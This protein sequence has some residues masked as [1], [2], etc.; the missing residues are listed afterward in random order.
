MLRN[1]VKIAWRSLSGNKLYT[2]INILG[3]ALGVC[4]CLVIYLVTSFELS[5][6]RF[7]PDRERIYRVV[8]ELRDNEGGDHKMGGVTDPMAMTMRSELSG[9][10]TVAG[11]Y[12]YYTKVRIPDGKK[13]S[14]QFDQPKY[15]TSSDIIITEPQY[16]DIFHYN[17]LAG[18]SQTAL[19]EPFRV[20]LSGRQVQR[21]F[22]NL[23]PDQA[24]G[25][26]VIYGDSLALTVSG[27]VEDWAGNSDLNFKDFISFATVANSPLK[28]DIDM[29]AWGMWNETTQAF[30]K[31][32][33]NVSP[34]QVERQFPAFVNRHLVMQPGDKN[35]LALQPLSDLHFN[36]DY[37]DSFSRKAHLPTLYALMA[38]AIFI[39][40]IAAI[41]F[42]N[43][44]TAQ[45]I[46]RTREIGIRKVLGGRRWQLIAQFLSETFLL[47]CLAVLLSALLVNP[48]LSLFHSFIPDGIR[49][50]I[51]DPGTLVFLTVL[52][53]TTSLLAGFYPARVLSSWM[54]VQSLKGQGSPKL[55]RKSPLRRSLIVFQ[56]TV[57]LV[58]I[59]GVLIVGN[60]IHFVLNKDMGFNKDAILNIRTNWSYPIS[61]QELFLQ[62]VAQLPEVAG[63]AT[64]EGTPAA[65]GHRG[66]DLVYKGDDGTRTSSQETKV[67]SQMHLADERFVPLYGIKL[68]A[69]RNLHHSDSMVEVLLNE[70][71]ARGLGFK[72]PADAIGRFVKS[73][74]MDRR[75]DQLLPVVGVVADFHS[76][77][78]HEPIAPVFLTANAGACRLVSIRLSSRGKGVDE[79]RAALSKIEKSWKEIY[80]GEK[81]DYAF[82]DETIAGFYE[83]EQK[84]SRIMNV[85]MFISIFISCMGLFGLVT[86]SAR[87]RTREIGIRKVM[88]A[89]VS[90]IVHLLSKEFLWLVGIAILIA[91]PLAWYFIHQWLQDF[92][93]RAPISAWVF[94]LAGLSAVL[95]ALAT[96]S[97][98]AF[99]AATANPVKSLRTE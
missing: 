23:A 68:L 95:I 33:K 63:V 87:Q 25:R 62:Q 48:V 27:V 38:I 91:S 54:P 5:Y 11:F 34:A 51:S 17:W 85:A 46:Q 45:S 44:S 31:L 84:T 4:A 77:S 90:G 76:Q 64:S 20:V 18:S 57:S 8:A 13:I 28:N 30:V 66:T 94:V 53:L 32:A 40:F 98:Q 26:Q 3:L 29:K 56:F 39:L 10:E 58:F 55:N 88:G 67:N 1:Y 82:F 80:P 36:A 74:Q 83:K 42:I 60:Q 9:F 97:V 21:Y 70:T 61:K 69:G 65:K 78:F 24:L 15:E 37:G 86:F 71:A 50:H 14:R 19:A 43:L 89:S 92:A 81:F 2:T 49:F 93:Y 47:T 16:F 52:T 99:K 75:T 12:H 6:D 79:T 22:G 41:N 59:I 72:K 96:V 73:G 7:H 35:T